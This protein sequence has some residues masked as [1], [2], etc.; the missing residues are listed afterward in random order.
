[1][2][3]AHANIMS[4][5][6]SIDIIWHNFRFLVCDENLP[7][8]NIVVMAI[9]AI[10]FVIGVGIAGILGI[11]LLLR[12]KSSVGRCASIN[13]YSTDIWIARAFCSYSPD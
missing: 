9:S 4:T 5:A 2:Y 12:V 11:L 6:D 13:M 7:V 10:F 1:M 3:I 8:W